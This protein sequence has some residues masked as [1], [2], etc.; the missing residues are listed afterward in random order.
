MIKLIEKVKDFFYTSIFGEFYLNILLWNDDRKLKKKRRQFILVNNP[1]ILKSSSQMR[2]DESTTLIKKKI[3]EISNSESKEDLENTLK[4]INNLIKFA[5]KD[6]N[7]SIKILKDVYVYKDKD[8]KN[9]TDKAKMLKIRIKHYDELKKGKE[10]RNLNRNIRMA[11]K[12]GDK[13]RV[14]KLMKEWKEKYGRSKSR[15]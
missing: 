12:K 2:Y 4:N 7:E 14:E 11:A 10:K 8:I 15:L 9:D 3:K 5:E 6:H 1:V 13:I